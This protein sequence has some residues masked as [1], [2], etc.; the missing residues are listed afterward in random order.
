MNTEIVLV[1]ISS[2][3]LGGIS[4]AAWI[5]RV[6]GFDLLRLGS[7]NLGATNAGRVMGVRIGLVVAGLDVLKGAAP[8]LL[9]TH[10][11]SQSAGFV[12][13]VCVVLGHV[14][15]PYLKFKGGKGVATALGAISAN[16]AVWLLVIIPL[17]LLGF[18]ITRRIGIGSVLGGL[19]L[20]G[21]A[22][23]WSQTPTQQNFGIFL[24]AVILIRHHRNVRELISALG[25][26]PTGE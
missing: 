19:G 24:A 1:G 21:S 15:S 5:A 10:Y 13:G 9:A 17:F 25:A 3:W 22:L 18:V 6:R 23:L 12:A 4:P 16:S 20:I 2:Y 14:L 8:T 11:V 26:K 7:G